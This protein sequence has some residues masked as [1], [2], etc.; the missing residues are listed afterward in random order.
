MRSARPRLRLGLLVLVLAT[1]SCTSSSGS[2]TTATANG[3][4]EQLRTAAHLPP[5]PVGLGDGLPKLTLR[6]L[7]GGPDVALRAQ[8]P[9]QP[10]LVNIWAT[11]CPPCV[12]EVPLLVSFANAAAGKVA[13]VG[14]LTEDDPKL[15]L[16]FARQFHMPY[17]SF[18]DDDGKVLRKFSS[19]PPVTLF[20]D[21]SGMVRF[22]KRGEIKTA[23]EL[24]RLVRTYLQVTIDEPASS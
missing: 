16:K 18:I 10:T 24:R 17:S 13:V 1:A 9:G 14:V 20:I 22:I 4:L 7:S 3:S 5:C 21:A 6:C 19:G 8:P 23:G 15:A 11:W 2:G 12:H